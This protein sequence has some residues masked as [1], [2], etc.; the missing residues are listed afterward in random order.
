MDY[1]L[2][3]EDLAFFMEFRTIIEVYIYLNHRIFWLN[4]E[5]RLYI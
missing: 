2:W 5:L 4:K 1:G 3:W